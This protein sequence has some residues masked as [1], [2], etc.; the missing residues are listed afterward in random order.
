MLSIEVHRTMN[1]QQVYFLTVI[2]YNESAFV[3]TVCHVV[4]CTYHTDL[5]TY[6]SEEVEAMSEEVSRLLLL[7]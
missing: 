6:E 4:P 5:G 1:R 7:S 3:N 2:A